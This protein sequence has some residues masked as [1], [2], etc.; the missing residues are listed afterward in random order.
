M[1][2]KMRRHY[3][4]LLAFLLLVGAML[5]FLEDTR[6]S[7]YTVPGNLAYQAAALDHENSID[8]FDE[9]VVHQIALLISPEDQATMLETYLETGEKDYFAADI[10]IDGLRV[11]QVGLRFKGNASLAMATGNQAEI[12]GDGQGRVPGMGRPGEP[13]LPE[14]FQP[15]EGLGPGQE[16][17]PPQGLQRPEGAPPLEN[18]Q[19]PEGFQ[20]PDKFQMPG[21]AQ[22]PGA[23]PMPGMDQEGGEQLPY[24]VKFDAFVPGQR[25]Q[26]L[27]EIAIRTSGVAYNAASM[28]EPVS[29][30]VMNQVGVPAPRSVYASVQLTGGEP[31]LYTL[32]EHIDQ[33]YLDRLYP[34][35]EGVLYKVTQV[36]NDF[37]YLGPDPTL[38]EGIFDQETA[39]ND[40][41]LAPLI[42]LIQFVSQADDQEFQEG[43]PQRLDVVAFADYLAIH[44]LLVNNDSLAG[45]GNN[46]YLYYDSNTRRF[47]ILSWDM[48]EG[49]GKIGRLGGA[50]LDI[51]WDA[52]GDD[53]GGFLGDVQPPAGRPGRGG[54]PMGGGR[55]LLKERFLADPEFRQLY[56]ERYQLRYQQVFGGDLLAPKIEEFAA[57]VTEYNARHTVV[58]QSAFDTA[59]DEL[60]G[61]VRQRGDYLST[62]DLLAD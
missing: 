39:K 40:A 46:Y 52:V 20:P 28:H 60:L 22:P 53:F 15:P 61:F 13:E 44:N 24:L 11:N 43:L 41:D 12:G 29:N 51:Y 31:T 42:D 14:G 5:L 9:T 49:L 23:M 27:A 59:V 8:L 55:H 30:Y 57:L 3:P 17:Q 54:G 58:D 36:G 19:M 45:M 6:I 56:W 10:I 4:L 16:F 21:G 18:S 7:A 33:I 50:D 25:Y 1:S 47:T 37:G 32:A 2:I 34:G 35:S 62:T 48:N 26:G 38:Y